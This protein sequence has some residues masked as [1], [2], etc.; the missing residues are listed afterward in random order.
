MR[1][2]LWGFRASHVFG[3]EFVERCG[4]SETHVCLDESGP[5]LCLNGGSHGHEAVL[6]IQ[7]PQLESSG[8]LAGPDIFS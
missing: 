7:I 5:F 8:I 1:F 3:S 6:A 4:G 2:G